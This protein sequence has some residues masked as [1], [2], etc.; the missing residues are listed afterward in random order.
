MVPKGIAGL[1]PKLLDLLETHAKMVV[2]PCRLE[3]HDNR[4]ECIDKARMC[5]GLTKRFLRQLQLLRQSILGLVTVI[6]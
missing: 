3:L 2:Q 4:I 1:S 5:I 6:H